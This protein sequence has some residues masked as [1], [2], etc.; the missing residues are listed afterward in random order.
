MFNKYIF[1]VECCIRERFIYKGNNYVTFKKLRSCQIK[2]AD[3]AFIR[4]NKTIEACRAIIM[5]ERKGLRAIFAFI[6]PAFIVSIAYINPEILADI[7][8]FISQD[9]LKPVVLQLC[10]PN[11]QK[12]KHNLE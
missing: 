4:Q 10:R 11:N 2:E 5:G 12:D 7:L 6:G 8:I 1:L 3:S 9:V